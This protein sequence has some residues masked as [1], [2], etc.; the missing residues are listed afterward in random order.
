MKKAVVVL[1]LAL[2]LAVAGCGKSGTKPREDTDAPP[3]NPAS[4]ESTLAAPTAASTEA[5]LA[6]PGAAHQSPAGVEAPLT[7]AELGAKSLEGA[8][9]APVVDAKITDGG[10]LTRRFSSDPD[11]LNPVTGRDYY[12]MLIN[13][14]VTDS[15]A[16]RNFDTFE[17][18]PRLARSWEISSDHLSYTFH[19]RDDVKWQDGVPFTSDDVVYTFDR[20]MDP[21]VDAPQA[22]N[23][24]TDVESVTAPD[25]YTVVFKWKKPYFL[26]FPTCAEFVPVARHVFDTGVDFNS[27]PAGRAPVGNGMYRFVNWKTSEQITLERN[28]GYYGRKP[29]IKRTVFRIVPDDNAALLM[30]SSGV[31]DV[32]GV[33]PDQWVKDIDKDIFRRDFNRYY[34]YDGEGSYG[35]IGWNARRPYFA[36]RRVRLAMTHLVDREGIRR[37]LLYGL[38]QIVTGT[39]YI[40][41]PDYDPSI[42]PWPYDPAE[43]ARLLDEADW[44]DHDGDGI[45]DKMVDGQSVKFTF[46]Y[47][48][49][50]G[51]TLSQKTGELLQEQLKK[52][53]VEMNIRPLEWATFLE[54][55]N[56]GDFDAVTLGWALSVEQDPYQLWHSSQ[57]GQRGSNSVAFRNAEADSVIEQARVE[58]D[59][60]KRHEL[61]HRFDA[62]LHDEQPY[63]FLFTTPS[64][65]IVNKRVHNVVPHKMRLDSREWYIPAE[66]Q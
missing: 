14:L 65:A 32:L 30:A 44:K 2:V 21:K 39:F 12:G 41:S 53:G 4:T 66:L 24:F 11:S 64:L 61:Y 38:A 43:A 59:A 37:N 45:R 13:E 55:L 18:E 48:F 52:A 54:R 58:F 42:K 5:A 49:P 23:Y 25:K 7:P 56:E 15:L 17:Y 47:M 29:H 3:A 57:I 8:N 16:K 1:L 60:A 9:P 34:Y 26:G 6:A 28:E 22:R 40:Y 63:T 31:I 10:T 35:Y 50:A 36:D 51:G 27:H 33:R 46:T 19:L 20:I 62:I